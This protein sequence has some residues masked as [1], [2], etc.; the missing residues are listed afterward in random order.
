MEWMFIVVV[1]LATTA[2]GAWFGPKG[3]SG[4]RRQIDSLLQS[5]ERSR[6]S[7][8]PEPLTVETVREVVRAS[9]EEAEKSA[10]L[11]NWMQNLFWF[12]LGTGVSVLSP[13]VTRYLFGT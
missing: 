5:I 3:M 13:L 6:A 11:G 1:G 7:T 8:Q 2:L 10:R 4:L 12:G 9:I